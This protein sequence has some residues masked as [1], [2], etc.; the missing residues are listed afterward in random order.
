M[1]RRKGNVVWNSWAEKNVTCS[2]E[3]V[4][5]SL[6]PFIVMKWMDNQNQCQNILIP[7]LFYVA[8]GKSVNFSEHCF[9][10]LIIEKIKILCTVIFW[11]SIEIMCVEHFA[12]CGE[13]CHCEVCM[14]LSS[15]MGSSLRVYA[16]HKL[17]PAACFISRTL[18]LWL[19]FLF[20]L[21]PGGSLR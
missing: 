21:H 7:S 3:L 5:S 10:H 18:L 14:L 20:W 4:W 15:L 13:L 11:D 19:F 2:L 6:S 1:T 12:C 8:Q 16:F 9:L 17:P